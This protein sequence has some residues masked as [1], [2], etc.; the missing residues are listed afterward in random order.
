[1]FMNIRRFCFVMSLG[2][3][4]QGYAQAEKV[5]LPEDVAAEC[6]EIEAQYFAKQEEMCVLNEKTRKYAEEISREKLMLDKFKDNEFKLKKREEYLKKN[7]NKKISDKEWDAIID[8]EWASFLEQAELE[9]R[10]TGSINGMSD[11][12]DPSSALVYK[13]FIEGYHNNVFVMLLL[14]EKWKKIHGEAFVLFKKMEAIAK[15]KANKIDAKD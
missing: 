12:S 4:A 7:S 11:F 10:A 15:T 1:M 8:A 5:N 2:F 13:Y 9:Y 14:M 6:R 3:V